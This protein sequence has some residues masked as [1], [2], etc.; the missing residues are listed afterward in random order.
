MT[1]IHA[2]FSLVSGSAIYKLKVMENV[3]LVSTVPFFQT[4]WIIQ[5]DWFFITV[6]GMKINKYI[7]ANIT[8]D[9]L[10]D[11]NQIQKT[12]LKQ[13]LGI[14]FAYNLERGKKRQIEKIIVPGEGIKWNCKIIKQKNLS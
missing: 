9:L 12:Q 10:Y 3:S 1:V 13:T 6:L 8:L 7:S 5:Q 4:I 14:G 11:H 2:C